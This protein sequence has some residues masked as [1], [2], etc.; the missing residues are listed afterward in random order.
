[1]QHLPQQSHSLHLLGRRRQNTATSLSRRTQSLQNDC[2]HATKG[3]AS[4]TEVILRHL[5]QHEDIDEVVK[6]IEADV[7]LRGAV[8]TSQA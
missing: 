3:I 6:Y 7:M 8:N 4:N 1:M 5:K 2:D